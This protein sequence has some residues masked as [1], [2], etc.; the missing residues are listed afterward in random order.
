M[1]KKTVN[2]SVGNIPM[3]EYIIIVRAH[4]GAKVEKLKFQTIKR[5]T[6]KGEPIFKPHGKDGWYYA[7]VVHVRYRAEAQKTSQALV[8]RTGL[9]ASF[10]DVPENAEDRTAAAPIF[11]VITEPQAFALSALPPEEFAARVDAVLYRGA[12]L[13]PDGTASAP[14]PALELVPAPAKPSSASMSSEIDALKADL[15]KERQEARDDSRAAAVALRAAT[16]EL[17][18][19]LLLARALTERLEQL[20]VRPA[21]TSTVPHVEAPKSD[22]GK[23]VVWLNLNDLTLT[24]R[25]TMAQA[26]L[27]VRAR[28]DL[29]WASSVVAAYLNN[30]EVSRVQLETMTRTVAEYGYHVKTVDFMSESP[31][32]VGAAI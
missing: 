26:I 31:N 5:S 9:L 20:T 25:K 28:P 8:L 15:L 23:G 3:G 27:L 13:N 12:Q 17:N 18:A 29:T 6:F 11:R 21:T 1:T 7:S 24:E 2:Y 19:V 14:P 22:S 16:A 32:G 30:G 10:E 4:S